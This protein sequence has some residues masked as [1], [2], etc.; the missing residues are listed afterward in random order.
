M[1]NNTDPNEWTENSASSIT[2]A[3]PNL[4][5]GVMGE[6]S[7]LQWVEDG[8]KDLREGGEDPELPEETYPVS[9]RN[10]YGFKF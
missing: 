7:S 1:A 2:M 9:A 8:D 3:L 10:F 6:T 4:E 5:T